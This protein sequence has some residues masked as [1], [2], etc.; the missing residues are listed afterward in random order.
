[1]G[2]ASW[3][4]RATVYVPSTEGWQELYLGAL[5]HVQDQM[6]GVPGY[7]AWSLL[8]PKQA[9]QGPDLCARSHPSRKT[10]ASGTIRTCPGPTGFPK[11]S[12]A[13]HLDRGHFYREHFVQRKLRSRGCSQGM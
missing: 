12:G 10:S 9:E 8:A 5:A 4:W 6:Q 3:L 1:M 7:N 11:P 13:Q 2:A